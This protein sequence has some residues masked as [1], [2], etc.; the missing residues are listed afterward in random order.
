MSICFQHIIDII[1]IIVNNKFM[2][3]K[4]DYD[5]ISD[6]QDFIRVVASLQDE[7][8]QRLAMMAA[9]YVDVG[10]HT[11]L[12]A[13]QLMVIFDQMVE[14]TDVLVAALDIEDPRPTLGVVFNE[15]YA[16]LEYLEDTNFECVY[17]CAGEFMDQMHDASEPSEGI[18]EFT[19]RVATREFADRLL[20]SLDSG[21][22]LFPD[23]DDNTSS[24]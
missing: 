1:V 24:E 9:E 15:Y 12:D 10:V 23:E 17:E 20:R 3:E 13:V 4:P 21:K 6:S 7:R 22:P 8:L 11:V 14:R 5:R 18:V 16:R 2:I 19:K